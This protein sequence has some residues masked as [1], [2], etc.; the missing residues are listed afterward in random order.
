MLNDECASIL[1]VLE[2]GAADSGSVSSVL[3]NDSGLKDGSLV[4]TLDEMWPR[5]VGAGLVRELRNGPSHVK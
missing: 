1:E 2:A 3:C 4:E 5:L